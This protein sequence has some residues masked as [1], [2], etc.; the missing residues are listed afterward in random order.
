M[1]YFKSH[2]VC[3]SSAN[4]FFA[5]VG[6]VEKA[7]LRA[8]HPNCS[9]LVDQVSARGRCIASA[10]EA[11]KFVFTG[12]PHSSCRQLNCLPARPQKKIIR[13]G[14]NKHGKKSLVESVFSSNTCAQPRAG[15]NQ[16]RKITLMR[17]SGSLLLFRAGCFEK[18]NDFCMTLL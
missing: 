3:R 18:F 6:R 12:S 4:S 9:K 14:E 16:S 8:L 2:I 7:G 11:S 15:V 17:Y 5:G 1:T 10:K 13:L